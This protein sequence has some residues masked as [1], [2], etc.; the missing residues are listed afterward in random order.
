MRRVVV[1][2]I[3]VICGL[4]HNREEFEAG[5]RTGRCGIG[6]ITN[7][8]CLDL[9]FRSGAEVRCYDANHH[10][11][12]K[13]ADMIDRFA[14]FALVSAREAVVQSGIEWTGDLRD[15]TAIVTGSCVGGQGTENQGFWDVYKMGKTRVHPMTI[16]KTMANA[17]ASAISQEFG[18]TGPAFTISTAC[19]SSAHAIGQAFSMVRSGMSDVAI[20][21]GS[22]APFSYGILKAWEA[23]RVI[24][25][26]VCRPFSKNRSGMILGEGAA[27]LVIE[28]LDHALARGAKPIAEIVGFGMSSDAHHI[29]QPSAEGAAK[30]VRMALK[31]A[32][33]APDQIGYIN[34]H[35]TGTTVNDP[36]ETRALHLAFGEHAKRLAISSTKAMHGH[37]LGAAGAIESTAAILALASGILPPTI[38]FNEPDPECDLDYIPNCARR[39]DPEYALSNSFAFGGL[40]AV[41]AFR[42]I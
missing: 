21:G 26:N 41:L 14:Q 4:G 37:T 7:I 16:P 25:P 19:S 2:G 8:E 31:D 24:S 38:H 40:N 15:S 32:G 34:A 11:S 3:G 17:G 20:T 1:T 23:M 13:E 22:E 9:R 36:T 33:I 42:R 6:P 29:T 12:P 28:A 39:A 35:G 5:L 10:F 30:A 27:M 18:I